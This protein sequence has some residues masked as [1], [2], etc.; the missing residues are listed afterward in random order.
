[1]KRPT[2]DDLAKTREQLQTEIREARETL[3]DLRYEI[4]TARELIPLLTDELFEAEVKKHVDALGKETQKAM[5]ATAQ[6]ITREFDQL[7]DMLMGRTPTDRRRGHPSIPELV[8][9]QERLEGPPE[10]FQDGPSRG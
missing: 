8:E 6:K 9:Q 10:T 5:D 4:K 1:M 7:A 2:T 3:K